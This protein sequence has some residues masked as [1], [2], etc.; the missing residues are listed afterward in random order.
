MTLKQIRCISTESCEG[1]CGSFKSRG[2]CQCDSMCVYYGSCCEDFDTVCPKKSRC[3]SINVLY[4]YISHHKCEIRS[5]CFMRHNRLP[6]F[7]VAT[8]ST[9]SRR[10]Q[11]RRRRLLRSRQLWHHV[12]TPF[13]LPQFALPLPIAIPLLYPTPPRAHLP[14]PWTPTQPPAAAVRLMPFCS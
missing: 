5:F 4:L 12:P 9:R 14:R 13:A 1:R 2:K 6:Q 7:P 3:R 11:K 10:F 8:P